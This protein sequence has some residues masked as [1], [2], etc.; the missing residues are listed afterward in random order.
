LEQNGDI[1][2]F[3]DECGIQE[4]LVREYGRVQDIDGRAQK[5][6]GETVG[7]RHRKTGLIA[8]YCKLP[9][10]TKYQ[11]ISPKTFKGN[12]NSEV[13]NDWII[14]DLFPVVKQIRQAYPDRNI[15]LIMDNVS[16]HKT[17][18]TKELLELNRINLVFQPTYSPDLNPIEPSWDTILIPSITPSFKH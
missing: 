6:Y 15:N 8:G 17:S 14:N 10:A 13:F 9:N 4:D 18:G 16:Y 2:I 11:Y 5:L 3:E 7:T 12:C 1:N